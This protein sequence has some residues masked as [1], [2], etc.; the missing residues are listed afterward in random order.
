MKPWD[1]SLTSLLPH[2]TVLPFI[3]N[4]DLSLLCGWFDQNILIINNDENQASAVSPCVYD[5][6]LDL[7][8]VRVET[9]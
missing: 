5:S 3:M 1:I 2:P 8:G 9:Q 7:N 4:L 6:D